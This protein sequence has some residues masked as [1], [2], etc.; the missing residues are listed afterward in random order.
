MQVHIFFRFVS[1]VVKGNIAIGEGG[2]D[3]SDN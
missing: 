3:I 2:G 1:V